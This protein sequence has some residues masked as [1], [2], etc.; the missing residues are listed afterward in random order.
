MAEKMLV[1]DDEVIV[2]DSCRKVFS[3]D[4]YEVTVTA[5]P[6]EG[7]ALAKGSRFGRGPSRDRDDTSRPLPRRRRPGS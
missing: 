3:S 2:L 6:R 1:I 7:L 5:S 4:G